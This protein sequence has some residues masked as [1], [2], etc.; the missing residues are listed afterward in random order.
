MAGHHAQQE[1]C[2]ELR[3]RPEADEC[4][5][6]VACANSLAR[7]LSSDS[8]PLGHLPP[9]AQDVSGLTLTGRSLTSVPNRDEYQKRLEELEKELAKGIN[10]D[11]KTLKDN[12]K[13]TTEDTPEEEMQTSTSV[14]EATTEQEPMTDE[15]EV[16]TLPPEENLDQ[17]VEEATEAETLTTTVPSTLEEE[18]EEEAQP[19][20]I[21]EYDEAGEQVHR[22]KV[23]EH[24]MVVMTTEMP[25]EEEDAATDI[26]TTPGPAEQEEEVAREGK[27][28]AGKARR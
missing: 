8:P 21:V 7:P 22:I 11:K 4:C 24:V 27:S 13:A 14:P 6:V 15:V 9:V 5:V 26:P 12:K 25:M 2:I 19:A 17:V 16:T 10:S 3:N 20:V 18:V 23:E 28:V 1:L